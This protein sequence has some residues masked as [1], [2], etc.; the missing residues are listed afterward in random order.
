MSHKAVSRRIGL[1]ERMIPPKSLVDR[2]TTH[3]KMSS[4]ETQTIDA[5]NN[6]AA[7][8]SEFGSSAG[9]ISAKRLPDLVDRGLADVLSHE[10][11]VSNPLALERFRGVVPDR[12]LAAV[13]DTMRNW[14][15][16]PDVSLR[17]RQLAGVVDQ[18]G[19]AMPGYVLLANG[20][21]NDVPD[22]AIKVLFDTAPR[23]DIP[24]H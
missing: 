1:L 17:I 18:V 8:L 20:C 24:S 3:L 21:V 10:V 7:L 23:S 19:Q 11:P 5:P 15:C 22:D 2:L 6:I 16:S 9:H 13:Y 14:G 4:M 12:V